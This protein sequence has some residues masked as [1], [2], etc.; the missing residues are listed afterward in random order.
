MFIVVCGSAAVGMLAGCVFG[1]WAGR[2]APDFFE[3]I[4]A[5]PGDPIRV[6]PEGTA[7]FL[8]SAVGVALGGGL[9]VLAV[10]VEA[11]YRWME[12]RRSWPAGAR[13]GRPRFLWGA[14]P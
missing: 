5:M 4:L 9:G 7:R 2:T 14:E 6:E 8:G 3:H 1:Q 11:F 12:T 13:P 10:L